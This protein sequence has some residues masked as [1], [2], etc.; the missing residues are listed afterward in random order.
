MQH[1]YRRTLML[2][3]DFNKVA[4]QLYWNHTST[5]LFSCKFAVYFQNTF[6]W[7]LLFFSQFCEFFQDIC[8]IKH[9]WTAAFHCMKS[10]HIWSYSGPYFPLLGL[11]N[12]E[13]GQFLRSVWSSLSTVISRWFSENWLNFLES[14]WKI[15][16]CFGQI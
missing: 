11:N 13:Y 15:L 9:Q 14:V 16:G 10:V 1:I 12:S 6:V 3:C 7:L 5:W 8:F 2:K 4:L